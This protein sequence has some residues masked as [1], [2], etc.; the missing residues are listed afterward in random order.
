LARNVAAVRELTK[1]AQAHGKTMAQLALAWVLN[2]P[3]VT[4]ALAGTK[5]PHQIEESCGA[6]GWV[7]DAATL[8]QIEEILQRHQAG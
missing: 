7:L 2:Q 8:A 4:C 5:R 6:A 1:I 3:G